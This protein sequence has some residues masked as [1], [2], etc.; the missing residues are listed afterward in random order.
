MLYADFLVAFVKTY[1]SCI[2][3][4]L[5]ISFTCR[6]FMN[7]RYF[8]YTVYNVEPFKTTHFALKEETVSHWKVIVSPLLIISIAVNI[9]VE[10]RLFKV[11]IYNLTI[12]TIQLQI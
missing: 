11:N 7:C 5:R 6:Y 10:T 8:I 9:F 1:L 2:N 3:L 12:K 4:N